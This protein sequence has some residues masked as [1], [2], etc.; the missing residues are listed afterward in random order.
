MSNFRTL[1]LLLFVLIGC[2]V[3]N[4]AISNKIMA[5]DLTWS[6]IGQDSFLI[7]LVVYR[8]CNG[9][10]LISTPVIASCFQTGSEITRY[11]INPG[12][13][14]DI[15]PICGSM[16]NCTRC[17]NL[18]CPFPYG[19]HR[20]TMH[21][22]INLS[23][24]GSCCKIKI[25]WQ[26]CCRATS[27]TISGNSNFYTEAVLNRCL[28]PCDNSPTFTD[29]PIAIL[30]KDQNVGYCG[31]MQDID[32]NS[33][34]GLADS[35]A[36]EWTAPLI[37]DSIPITYL[38]PY[39]YDKP[40][41]FLGFPYDTLPYPQGFLLDREIGFFQ[42]R[43]VKNGTTQ[44]VQKGIEYRDGKYIGEIRRE[45]Y[46]VVI[47]CPTN[48]PPT[49]TTLNGIRSKSICSGETVSFDF[50]ADDPDTNDTVYISWNNSIPGATWS[51]TNGQVKHPTGTL[52]WATR[53]EYARSLPYT[54]TVT[55][56]DDACPV[57]GSFTES[58]QITI[59]PRPQA[60]IIITDSCCFTF[61]L[62]A[63][64]IQGSGPSYLWK[65]ENFQF[66][67]EVGSI[68]WHKFSQP[69]I[70][71]FTMTM[72]A[73]GCSKTYFDTIIADTL[74]FISEK[75]ISKPDFK[76]YPNPASDYV[77][78]VYQGFSKWEGRI[79]V[80]DPNTKLVSS[81]QLDFNQTNNSYKLPLIAYT[82]GIYL[83]KLENNSG[84]ILLK[85][86]KQ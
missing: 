21:G 66:R 19:I 56:K 27:T 55:A 45:F 31:G 84:S 60:S 4:K 50:I 36:F 79:Q 33:T 72:T 34:G 24:A 73:S 86:L 13:P 61:W 83:L 37:A 35:F 42:F 70:Y 63:Q 2:F 10:F 75:L 23:N 20:Y 29:P 44:F 6:C 58:Y 25:E 38:S 78:I 68:V 32:V 14:V 67:P 12:T 39:S 64:R 53:D 26:Q 11:L 18:S 5:S 80:F 28:S 1:R 59:N 40:I 77:N 48:N 71:P 81:F 15:T 65:G 74:S 51:T 54:F 82:P 47:T 46:F 85:L 16:S 22:I 9:D 49:I 41:E 3:T 30:C 43:P 8:D 7:K 17:Q 76:I 62:L 69:G 52:T 57:R